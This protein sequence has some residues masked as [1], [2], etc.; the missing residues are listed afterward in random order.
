MIISKIN[1][2]ITMEYLKNAPENLYFDRKRAKISNQDLVNE[3]ASF[4]N[5][6]GGILAIGITDDGQIEGFNQ[7]GPDKLNQCQ[8]VVTNYLK[9]TPNYNIELI[10]VKN[11]KN[12]DDVIVLFHIKS[13]VNFVVRNNRDEVYLRQ[14]DSSIKLNAEQI[15][16]LEYE[17]Q[18]R[19]FELEVIKGTNIKDVDLEILDIYKKKIGASYIDDEQVLK[20]RGF[21]A[22]NNGEYN[23]TKAG[24]LLFGKN[25]SIYLPSAR[26]RV[27]KFEGTNFQVG[28]NMN[29]IKDRT[30]DKCL[31]RTLEEAKEFINSQLREFTYLNQDGIFVTV[32]EYP[33]F[34]WYEGLVNAITH[35]DYTN[36]GE[37]ITIKLFDDRLEILSPGK[38]GGFVT[39]ENMQTKRYSRNPQIARVL[40]E[41]GIVRELNEGVK[42]IYSEMRKFYLKDPIYSEPEQ[43]S[44]LLVLDNNIVM[45]SK[46][47]TETMLKNIDINGKWE[48]LNNM[49]KKVL[50]AIYDKGEI[51]STEVANIIE[52]GKTTTIKLLNKLIEQELII[53]T[54][55]SKNDNYGR[56]I[57]K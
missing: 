14:G 51:T 48:T 11:Q 47:K 57:I 19:N 27:L 38:L 5:A 9:Q 4:A 30:F 8:K 40:T 54:G 20:S 39:L 7:Y 50:Q 15:R 6:N 35:R 18:E 34:A 2:S 28:E 29:I 53:W 41:L 1:T 10:N 25:P 32:P 33:E 23:L 31:Y 36:N 42:R 13:A 21:L 22:E 26:V 3:I 52:R 16:S 17:R 44:V 46:R 45:R 37:Y 12:E 49:E 55:T 43:Q 24:M 56:Y